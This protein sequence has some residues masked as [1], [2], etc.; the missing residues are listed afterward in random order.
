MNVVLILFFFLCLGE[1]RDGAVV[2]AGG[3]FS[4]FRLTFSRAVL[5]CEQLGHSAHE[6]LISSMSVHFILPRGYPCCLF[7]SASVCFCA[8]VFVHTTD[9]IASP[10]PPPAPLPPPPPPNAISLPLG[11]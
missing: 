11:P 10:P 4:A 6:S 5:R 8:C 3:V 1:S 7:R 2:V 9:E